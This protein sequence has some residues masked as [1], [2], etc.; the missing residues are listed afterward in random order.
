M[1]HGL[2][3]AALLGEI[4]VGHAD[5]AELLS[6]WTTLSRWWPQGSGHA[7][8]QIN[9]PEAAKE[10]VSAFS[11]AVSGLQ[12]GLGLAVDCHFETWHSPL[13]QDPSG[14]QRW[15]LLQP[16]PA[17][18]LTLR[19]INWVCD[20]LAAPQSAPQD[21]KTAVAHL[22]RTMHKV[23]PQSLNSESI[24]DAALRLG[25]PNTR[26]T[27]G[28][29]VLGLG[30]KSRWLQSTKSHA[31]SALGFTLAQSKHQ[32]AEILRSF[33][34]PGADHRFVHSAE[35][36]AQLAM[37]WGFPLVIKPENLDRGVGVYADLRDPA[38]VK[39][40]FELARKHSHKILLE[41]HCPGFT[42]RVSVFNGRIV[43]VS[44]RV[45]GGVV[46]NGRQTVR[47]LVQA[48]QQT[49]HQR[50]LQ[51]RLGEPP[52]SL[53][54]ESVGL[55]Q[56]QG[57]T[58]EDIPT[59]GAYV[60]LRRRDNINAGG[61]NELV[62]LEDVHP[63]NLELSMSAAAL[64]G[65]DFAGIDLIIDDIRQSWQGQPALICEV[66]AVPQLGAVSDPDAYLHILG[67][68]FPDGW[69]IPNLLLI[70]PQAPALR[71]RILARLWP[72]KPGHGL[73]D[74][75]GLVVGGRRVSKPFTNDF[76]AA[77]ALLVRPQ[78]HRA[79]CLMSPAE[80]LAMGTPL[81]HWQS[82]R[83]LA[84]RWFSPEE[85][86]TLAP[87]LAALARHGLTPTT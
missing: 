26:L 37:K 22:S 66:N 5:S 12:R 41:R 74:R 18:Q 38:A 56:Q 48:E 58:S 81:A 1:S 70:A 36:A 28:I 55:L 84:E 25:L 50:Q 63:D 7:V 42:H 4:W 32:T 86:S 53:D 60:R 76:S 85:R 13:A 27:A 10:L 44:R 72:Q 39:Q 68:L 21:L 30:H 65:L 78:I 14:W 87:A 62:P 16:G 15:V 82:I 51:Q 2:Q 3:Q 80:V 49:P 52:L 75:S 43:R 11:R 69:Q 79:V 20:A 47:E 19:I 57:L 83:P 6:A 61:R 40:A 23:L 64:L 29:Q 8:P 45:A 71:A 54:E 77:R 46:G 73:S 24:A 34:L 33:G 59:E 17:P 35:E 67:D 31:T 9:R